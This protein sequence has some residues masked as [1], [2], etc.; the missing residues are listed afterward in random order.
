MIEG[1]LDHGRAYA[2]IPRWSQIAL[3]QLLMNLLHIQVAM[4]LVASLAGWLYNPFLLGVALR[5]HLVG[6]WLGK[7][8]TAIVSWFI[9]IGRWCQ[10]LR[11]LVKQL[12]LNWRLNFRPL[13]AISCP[14]CFLS[15]LA[16]RCEFVLLRHVENRIHEL[17]SDEFASFTSSCLESL[18]VLSLR[19]Q[20]LL[21]FVILTNNLGL[22][23]PAL[24]SHPLTIFIY[25]SCGWVLHGNGDGHLGTLVLSHY[26][27]TIAPIVS[28][29][30]RWKSTWPPIYHLWLIASSIHDLI[31]VSLST[32]QRR[33]CILLLISVGPLSRHL[34]CLNTSWHHSTM[35]ILQELVKVLLLT[36][37]D[38]TQIS[39]RIGLLLVEIIQTLGSLA[40]LEYRSLAISHW[41]ALL[42]SH[43]VLFLAES[44]RLGNVGS[45]MVCNLCPCV[46]HECNIGV[47]PYIHLCVVGVNEYGPLT[48]RVGRHYW[49]WAHHGCQVLWCIMIGV[50]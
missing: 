48:D 45:V 19:Y 28:I 49:V 39:S 31:W 33:C 41:F 50:T 26:Y 15:I 38:C 27:A 13:T 10:V 8:L 9:D 2:H 25:I 14:C 18:L 12:L 44:A 23:L 21:R 46:L 35:L 7:L 17:F 47:I 6:W 40:G 16:Q 3:R 42:R 11:T 30:N 24:L 20:V 29:L 4:R 37:I 1:W 36:P 5:S 32:R 43:P 34:G 22:R